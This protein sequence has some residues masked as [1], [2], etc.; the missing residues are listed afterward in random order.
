MRTDG[1]HDQRPPL[2]RFPRQAEGSDAM[3]RYS[4]A[5]SYMKSTRHPKIRIAAARFLPVEVR[6]AAEIRWKELAATAISADCRAHLSRDDLCHRR[7]RDA[8]DAVHKKLFDL[9]EAVLPFAGPFGLLEPSCTSR[10][11]AGAIGERGAW[12]WRT[13][14]AGIRCFQR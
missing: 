1:H 9:D 4:S 5:L 11:H 2:G 3:P 6:E 7:L 13:P 12:P 8:L 14:Q 10:W